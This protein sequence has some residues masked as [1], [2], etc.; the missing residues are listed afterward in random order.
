MS[1]S[2]VAP[3]GREFRAQSAIIGNDGDGAA[4]GAVR[5]VVTFSCQWGRAAGRL[6]RHE[7]SD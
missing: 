1:L 2:H 4:A 5:V 3:V 7:R 6:M